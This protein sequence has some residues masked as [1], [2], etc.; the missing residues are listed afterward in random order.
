MVKRILGFLILVPIVL[1]LATWVVN[2]FLGIISGDI[3]IIAFLEANRVLIVIILTF[4][5]F[6]FLNPF[7]KQ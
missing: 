6:K 1:I 2:V 5:V 3:S 7:K 4:L